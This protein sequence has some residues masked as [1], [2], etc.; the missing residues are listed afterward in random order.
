MHA[1]IPTWYPFSVQV[2]LNG[3]EWLARRL[4]EQGLRNTRYEN[5]FPVLE[6]PVRAQAL[7]M[8]SCGGLAGT[9]ASDHPAA[10]SG[11]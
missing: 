10:Q 4:D 7:M 1:R 2:C 11:A 5:R 8:I 9:T 3:R 6:D